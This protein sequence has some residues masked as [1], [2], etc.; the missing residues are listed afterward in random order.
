MTE[1]LLR[2]SS[3]SAEIVHPMTIEMRYIRKFMTKTAGL[4]SGKF[5]DL[6]S[7]CLQCYHIKIFSSET[8]LMKVND[9]RTKQTTYYSIVRDN[10]S[11][12]YFFFLSN[13]IGQNDQRDNKLTTR[14]PCRTCI[15]R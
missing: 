5:S 7:A 9:I 3:L 2:H 13:V 10:R 4:Q 11:K 6:N 12:Q 14:Y 1:S 15:V 8:C